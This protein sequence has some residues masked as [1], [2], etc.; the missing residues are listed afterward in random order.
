MTWGGVL[1]ANSPL[2]PALWQVW[3]IQGAPTHNFFPSSSGSTAW[4]SDNERQPV[5]SPKIRPRQTFPWLSPSHHLL[6]PAV[7]HSPPK[8]SFL[9]GSSGQYW[10]EISP[11]LSS[12]LLL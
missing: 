2:P 4:G 10:Q 5:P 12:H 1:S 7:S 6:L 11:D 3:S 8:M 9:V